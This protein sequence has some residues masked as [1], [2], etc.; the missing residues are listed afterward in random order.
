M[1]KDSNGTRNFNLVRK[2]NIDI[3]TIRRI[4]K[5]SLQEKKPFTTGE[6]RCHRDLATFIRM[7][8]LLM[9]PKSRSLRQQAM[10]IAEDKRHIII[11]RFSNIPS[12]FNN[13]NQLLAQYRTSTETT[14]HQEEK[15]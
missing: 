7:L 9:L 1:E 10:F 5:F 2:E 12:H 8:H 11:L 14:S 3:A 4:L 13:E 6:I 15:D